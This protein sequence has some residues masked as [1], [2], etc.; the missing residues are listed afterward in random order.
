MFDS[1]QVIRSSGDIERVI[2][3]GS[4]AQAPHEVLLKSLTLAWI[5]WS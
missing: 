1:R 4:D 3:T 2:R 5:F